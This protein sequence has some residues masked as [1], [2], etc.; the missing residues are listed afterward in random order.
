MGRPGSTVLICS[1][2]R[3]VAD[4]LARELRQLGAETTIAAT[5]ADWPQ[6][7]PGLALLDLADADHSAREARLAFGTDLE[8]I[9]VVDNESV[10][11]LLAAL[12]AGC[13]D[14]LFYPIN[15]AELGLRWRRHLAGQG[16]TR[17][18]RSSGLSASLELEFPSSVSYVRDVVAEV[19]EACQ[20]MAF[21]GSRATLNLRV[22]IGEALAN[23]IL[24]GNREDPAKL[25]R[26]NA[27]LRPGTAVVTITDEGAGFDPSVVGDPT[28]PE[29][30]WRSHGRGLFLLRS[31]TDDIRFNEK[32]N[33]VTLTLEA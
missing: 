21:T 19:V 11:R 29:N 6:V 28:R 22:A 30:R 25:V 3:E 13:G 12:A 33:S 31:L 2:R 4:D 5:R 7:A 24:Y 23:A 10:D 27:E 15:P 8:L 9:A 32:G 20:R 1:G 16:G 18:L 17:A 26:V 14:Y